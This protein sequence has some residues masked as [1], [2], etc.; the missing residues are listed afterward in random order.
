MSGRRGAEDDAGAVFAALA[1]PTRRAV[2]R[3]VAEAGP[4]TATELAG[5]LPVS[6]QAIAKHLAVLQ[7]AGLVTPAKEGRENRFRATPARLTDVGAWL[8]DTGS[9]WDA[10]LD[11][12]GDRLRERR[13]NDTRT[14][15][16]GDG[17]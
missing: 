8:T 5:R 17:R 11:R 6:R 4:L 9:A 2:L 14:H 10:R 16:P 7:Q 15:G 1:D 13:R 12:L 3:D